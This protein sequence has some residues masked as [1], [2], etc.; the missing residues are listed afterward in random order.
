MPIAVFDADGREYQY[1]IYRK[2]DPFLAGRAYYFHI[3]WIWKKL[4]AAAVLLAGYT[5]FTSFSKR[6][7][8]ARTFLCAISESVWAEEGI[9]MY[10][11][12]RPIVFCGAW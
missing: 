11:V 10:T 3:P 6:N 1:R 12:Y 8:Q 4:G 5:D 7:T 9:A 2:K